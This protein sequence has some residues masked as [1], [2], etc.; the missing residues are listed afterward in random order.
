MRQ[1]RADFRHAVSRGLRYPARFDRVHSHA[2]IHSVAS[3]NRSHRIPN[4]VAEHLNR[5]A[6]KRGEDDGDRH[7]SHFKEDKQIPPEFRAKLADYIGSDFDRGHMAPAADIHG[8]QSMID[9]SFL[10]N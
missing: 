8:K 6:L 4:W 5:D 2:R 10:R 9:E 7:R 3:Y 1:H